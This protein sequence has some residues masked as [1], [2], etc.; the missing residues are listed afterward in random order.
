[1]IKKMF[2]LQALAI[3]ICSTVSFAATNSTLYTDTFENYT[4]GTPLVDG[5]NYWYAS[6]A[7]AVVQTGVVASGSTQAA[8]IP[9][10]VTLSNRCGTTVATN[11]TNVWLRMQ[12][13]IVKYNRDAYPTYDTNSTAIF[14]VN[15][16]GYF[17]V[18]NGTV[19][20]TTLTNGTPV[21]ET[22]FYLV[23]VFLDYA[24]KTWRLSLN[25]TPLTNN[26]GFVN[27]AATN[28]SGFEVYNA[29]LSTSYLDNV[30]VYDRDAL[31]V[32]S[33]DPSSLINE[34]VYGANATSQPFNIISHG[35]GT[36]NYYIV[37]NAA[38]AGWQ[39]EI[40]NN[41]VGTLVNNATNTVWV[42]YTTASKEPGTY[43]N[44]FNIV[45]TNYEWQT[46]RVDVVVRV[47]GLT[48]STTNLTSSKMIG[49]AA[50]TQS[51]EVFQTGDGSISYTVS[52][53]PAVPWLVISSGGSGTVTTNQTNTVQI[54]YYTNGLT[55]GATNTSVDVTANDNSVTQHINIAMTT[56]SRPV[57]T[58]G[59]TAY[60]QTIQ[61]GA[62][63]TATNLN[64][65]NTAANPL[66]RMNYTV[67]SDVSW[68]TVN[69]N[70]AIV[71]NE[72]STV[73]VT[74]GDMSTN[75][76]PYTGHLTIS[77]TDAGTGYTP[78]GQVTV[79]T[80][81][82]VNVLVIAPGKAAGL[83]ATKATY[84]NGVYLSWNTTTN[85]DHFELWRGTNSS[86][87]NNATRFASSVAATSYVDTTSDPGIKNYYWVRTINAYGGGGDYSDS[88]QGW[89]YLNAP[90][91]VTASDGEYTNKVLVGWTASRG[92]LN[93]EIWRSTINLTNTA[94]LVGTVASTAS[95]Y[96]DISA[97]VETVYY[98]WVRS[99]TPYMGTFS[100]PNTGYRSALMKPD[101]VVASDGEFTNKVRIIWQ[102]VQ[103]AQTYEVW[104]AATTNR[105]SA[106]QIG[107]ATATGYDDETV[108][109]GVYYYYWVRAAN[110]EGYSRYSDY[111]YGWRQLT[112][113][114]GIA[115]SDGTY[116]YR[117]RVS[118][119][120]AE[121]ATGYEVWRGQ[122]TGQGAGE[123]AMKVEETLNTY[124]D[125]HAVINATP[126][127]YRVKAINALGSSDYSTESDYGWR[128]IAPATTTR[129]VKNDYDGDRL[130]DLAVYNAT[131][132]VWEV[133]LT[134]IGQYNLSFGNAN[135]AAV[136]GDYDGDKISDPMIYW[137]NDGD[138]IVMLSS[139]GYYPLIAGRFG[140]SGASAAPADYDGDGITDLVVY[141]ESSGLL[142]VLFS[143]G[144]AFNS[145]V[146]VPL[147]GS[148]W[149]IVSADYDGDAKADPAVYS[150]SAGQL[151]AKLSG[152][153]YPTVV[154]PIGGAGISM[155]PAD[156][157]GD[158][159]ADLVTY[160]EGTG[161]WV[162]KLSTAG[163]A[164]IPFS[165]G[166]SGYRPVVTDYDGDSKT[167]P[168]LYN[169][170]TG[171]WLIKFSGSGYPTIEDT[172]GGTNW[173]PVGR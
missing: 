97:A 24:A 12:P 144:G 83:S 94:V 42:K 155:H 161:D 37:T 79:S 75:S 117:I 40:T 21:S 122:G 57:P 19:E 7:E 125:D 72:S 130:A 34:A 92:A 96:D 87:T 82:T 136:Q 93:Y 49:Y 112:P 138:W 148:G 103:N 46:Q 131:S 4:N 116:P 119:N 164:S 69:T 45:S 62:A 53:N 106:T 11:S 54:S 153:G 76:G 160:E 3:L 32:L 171:A 33:V 85:M 134:A 23:D 151:V 27:T 50:A 9:I 104:R 16:N 100:D 140:G 170:S 159:I 70:G 66:T 162:A 102:A 30:I 17:V 20:W 29:G 14:Y 8:M 167:D 113:P 56:Y 59:F 157:D 74:F 84:T 2:G 128:A 18:R 99:R 47:R 105:S 158:A 101:G 89:V 80:Q 5:T 137:Q 133:L 71:S 114:S 15:S 91:D 168:A 121:N 145:S 124:Y 41:A 123:G 129:A 48:V 67:A 110:Y 143:N 86:V 68:L 141:N 60:S 28:F 61:K 115:A 146:S 51:F 98:Y 10:D 1:M 163:Y 108:P 111:D 165:M 120:A 154:V 118:W 132:G 52:T 31:P 38:S 150:A 64:I 142:S 36:L 152:S 55:A 107:T 172:Y 135:S 35:D 13:R 22:N 77:G 73:A 44:S 166:G 65:S 6:S 26:I 78:T 147:G 43:S 58:P 169:E 90:N 63:P 127:Y 156:Y 139:I 109:Q 39:M 81:V 88:D 149:A 95:S 25:S 126:Y 173:V